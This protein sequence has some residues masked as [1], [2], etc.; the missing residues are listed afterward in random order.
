M[1]PCARRNCR[2]RESTGRWGYSSE[3]EKI[4]ENDGERQA[5][6]YLAHSDSTASSG[7]QSTLLGRYD[8]QRLCPAAES[9][10]AHQAVELV[11]VVE[12]DGESS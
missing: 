12:V 7:M 5:R 10:L 3:G 4:V 8:C 9:H 1:I 6:E 2:T 11:E